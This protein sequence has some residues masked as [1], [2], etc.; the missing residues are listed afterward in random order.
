VVSGRGGLADWLARYWVSGAAFVAAALFALAP[1]LCGL[2]SLPL[3]LIYLHLP[4]YMAHQVEEHTGDRFR[5]F[6]NQRLFGGIEALSTSDV[7]WINLPGVWG[8][9][10]AALYAGWFW[11][12]GF[13]LGAPYLMLVNAVL[14]LAALLRFRV[15]NPGLWTG[16]ILF[17]PLSLFTLR[18][19]SRMPG[20]SVRDHVAGFGIAVLVH[21]AIVIRTSVQAR[22][23]RRGSC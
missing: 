21:A 10:L 6:V 15:Y 9:N 17:L 3:V 4:V 11:G 20:T 18:E 23:A 1:L 5:T 7:L 16:L 12:A 22:R 8:I 13:G 19:V 14:H 2:M